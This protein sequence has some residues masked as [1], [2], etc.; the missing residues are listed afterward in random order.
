MDEQDP[1]E[2]LIGFKFQ[3]LVKTWTQTKEWTVVGSASWS[4]NYVEIESEDGDKTV[5]PAGLVRQAKQRGS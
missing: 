3:A 2:D 1:N 5:R 4:S